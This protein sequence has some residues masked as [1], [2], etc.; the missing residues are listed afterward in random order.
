MYGKEKDAELKT[1]PC[2]MRYDELPKRQQ[3][4]DKLFK[5]VVDSFKGQQHV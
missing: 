4:K 3:A 1:H 2:I 5:S